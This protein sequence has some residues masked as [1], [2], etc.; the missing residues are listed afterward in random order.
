[1][2]E[3]RGE[4]ADLRAQEMTDDAAPVAAAS[5]KPARRRKSALRR[6]VVSFVRLCIFIGLCAG[7]FYYAIE[8]GYLDAA[9]RRE[10]EVILSRAIGAEHYE[11]TVAA[12]SLRFNRQGQ[13]ALDVR[14]VSLRP[15]AGGGE[16]F[17]AGR[18]QIALET[19]QLL[20]GQ[21]KA[22]SINIDG[23]GIN[24][25]AMP[26]SKGVAAFRIDAIPGLLERS[27]SALDLFDD[28][29][30]KG[31]VTEL[32]LSGLSFDMPAQQ[33]RHVPVDIQKVTLRRNADGNL[34]IN[35]NVSIDGQPGIFDVSA[36]R[37]EF[38]FE[39]LSVNIGSLNIRPFVLMR[40][41]QGVPFT[42]LD[43][44]LSVRLEA[45]GGASQKPALRIGLSLS[46][47]AFYGEAES[48]AVTRGEVSAH[49]DF[50]ANKIEVE[51]SALEFG[52]TRVPFT[53]GFIDMDRLNK[54]EKRGIGIDL[55][56][57][58]GHAAPANLGDS[59]VDF[60]GKA[61]GTFYP[62]TLEL[63][64]PDLLI[65]STAGVIGGSLSLK[66]RAP[67]SPG[68]VGHSPEVSLGLFTQNVQANAIRALWPF[69]MGAKGR[70]WV[71][72]NL[73]G[74]TI[75][76][77]SLALFL[78]AGILPTY[79]EDHIQLDEN[80]LKIKFDIA[81]AR[82]TLAGDIPPMRDSIAHFEMNGEHIRVDIAKGAA[83]F[84]SGRTIDID[85]GS[86][87]IANVSQPPAMMTSNFKLSGEAAALVELTTYR[88]ISSLQGIGFKP[89]D[90]KGSASV[91]LRANFPLG[92]SPNAPKPVWTG[93]LQLKDV[94]ISKPF[95]GRTI[96]G[97]TG[98][99]KLNPLSASLE[100]DAKVD[101]VPLHISMIQPLNSDSH[102]KAQRRVSGSVDA[103]K[104]AVLAPGIENIISGSVDLDMELLADGGQSV[105]A[106]LAAARLSVPWAGWEKGVGV[107]A[108]V[109]FTSHQTGGAFAISDFTLAGEDFGVAGSISA[110][111]N[112]LAS[113]EFSKV[114]LAPTDDLSM[115]ITREGKRYK[116]SA[117][118]KSADVRGLLAKLKSMSSSD[119]SNNLDVSVSAKLKVVNGFNG[120]VLKNVD[121][122]YAVTG[123][124]PVAVKLTAVT[125]GD[126]AIVAKLS[127]DVGGKRSIDMTATDAGSFI[128][129][130]GL[131]QNM[132]GG[133][134][135][136]KIRY[137]SGGVWQG[138]ADV[139]D[140]QLVNEDRLQQIVSTKTGKDGKSLNEAVKR[141]IDVS[142]QK[143]SRGYARILI[144]GD[145]ASL[146]NGV[147]R[148]DQVGATFQG[149]LRDGNGNM[150]MTGTFMPAY[151]LNRL[152]AE[153]PVIG[154]ILGNGKDRGLIGITFR[155]S[156]PADG[157]KLEINPLSLIAPG[158]FRN[159]FEFQ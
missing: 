69:W 149:V 128:R 112:G 130:A 124:K 74:G 62:D 109:S 36:K 132:R 5:P 68:M 108:K 119:T 7:A 106:D 110:D 73:F 58:G 38:G 144:D 121:A 37:G 22:S 145:T 10:A 45:K 40:S 57:Q 61:F 60:E 2:A 142:S 59:P 127:A 32:A 19:G 151:G 33:N 12:T 18:V 21:V 1:M 78:P 53:A 134:L 31:D 54:P 9:L 103:G 139:R 115:T 51:P 41:R 55:L 92:V 122:V 95:G 84:P 30:R 44:D 13:L 93:T 87:E 14:G 28:A 153:L 25:D 140:F 17:R 46:R 35:G 15:S 23:T 24:F 137:I 47:A 135:N 101:G 138:V 117:S 65:A 156:G 82:V 148:G 98:E 120:E 52:D 26:I 39:A 81:D 75:T 123:G 20:T 77:G 116:I 71:Y 155:L 85:G 79:P 67:P 150:N 66:F 34:T 88:P 125:G 6:V 114:K 157:P 158:V 111:K 97:V 27:F 80:Q 16:V 56:I 113:A 131:Y 89:E 159:I 118:G 104:L 76:N 4:N 136:F 63:Q 143:F 107:A 72:G 96:S 86:F 126:Q 133:L 11:A 147:V 49:Y 146:E 129:F 99:M 48:S 100:A 154:L 43:G 70:S 105:K 42:G 64:A 90:F 102:Q 83:F 50:S 8:Q 152:F 29:A 141:N 3:D 94:S 91:A